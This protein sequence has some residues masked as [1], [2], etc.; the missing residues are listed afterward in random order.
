FQTALLAYKRAETN[1]QTPSQRDELQLLQAKTLLSMR[2]DVAAVTLLARLA[3]V[4]DPKVVAPALGLL[5][6]TKLKQGDHKYG[7]ALLQRAVEW[8][9]NSEW[10]GRAE[11][12]ADLGLAYL[13][14]GDEVNGLRCLHEAQS[15]LEK[16]GAS[17]ML[18]QCLVN[19]AHYLDR[20]D[21]KDQAARV[22]EKINRVQVAANP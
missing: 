8:R 22:Q 4:P 12:Q 15:S 19:E 14:N 1:A 9:G 11:A 20:T 17:D 6:S 5:G 2:Q 16:E 13:M 7:L 18:T 3:E 10:P 21:K